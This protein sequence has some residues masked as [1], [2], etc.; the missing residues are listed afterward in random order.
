MKNGHLKGSP[1]WEVAEPAVDSIAGSKIDSSNEKE[2]HYTSKELADKKRETVNKFLILKDKMTDN[3]YQLG[4]SFIQNLDFK[5][6]VNSIDYGFLI[7][8]LILIISFLLIYFAFK[9]KVKIILILSILNLFLLTLYLV[10]M[11]LAGFLEDIDQIKYG[12]YFF[13][14]NLVLISFEAYKL[15]KEL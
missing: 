10:L 15:K 1:L 8:F 13:I 5:D 4:V 9:N 11:Y 3:G 14:I 7:F 12:Y 2:Y 6:F